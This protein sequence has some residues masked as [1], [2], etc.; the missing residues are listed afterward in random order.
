VRILKLFPMIL[1]SLASASTVLAS[2]QVASPPTFSNFYIPHSNGAVPNAVN[3]LGSVVGYYLSKGVGEYDSF[4]WQANGHVT[5]VD[6]PGVPTTYAL[7]IN[8]AGWIAGTYY[9]TQYHGFLRNPQYTSLDVPGAGSLGTQAMSVNDAGEIAGIYYDSSSVLHGF[10][11][12]VSGNYTTF[13]AAGQTG[14]ASAFLNQG[15]EIA[16]S[17][18]VGSAEA[19][20]YVRDALGQVTLFDPANSVNTVISGIN[21]NGDVAG[22]Y[23]SQGT[24]HGFLRDS[25]GNITTFDVSGMVFV[26][27]ISDNGDVFGESTNTAAI[28]EGWRRTASGVISIF[29]DPAAGGRGTRPFCVSPDGK[30]AGYYILNNVTFDFELH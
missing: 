28:Y 29:K 30:V 2:S 1:A 24:N 27:G 15:G 8:G 22:T 10:F 9:D 26:S 23:L 25:L 11:R 13:D 17:Y 14:V 4:L 16:G 19:H 20:G 12:D 18:I 6:F 3:N 7:S 21:A 5:V